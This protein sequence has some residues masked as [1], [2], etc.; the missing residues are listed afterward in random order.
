MDLL[1]LLDTRNDKHFVGG[2]LTDVVLTSG[3]V[4]FDLSARRAV[5]Y[6][7]PDTVSF[8]NDY[9]HDELIREMALRA[10]TVLKRYDFQLFRNTAI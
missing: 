8:S 5:I 4:T 7:Q 6:G 9:A 10:L 3:A 1:I 2:T